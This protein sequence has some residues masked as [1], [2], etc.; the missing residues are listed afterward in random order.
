VKKPKTAPKLLSQ[1]KAF[2][3][4]ARALCCDESEERFDAALAKVARHKPTG[5]VVVAEKE[6]KTA[7]ELKELVEKAILTTD[8]SGIQWIKIVPDDPSRG[9]NWRVA[10]SGSNDGGLWEKI[11]RA[12]EKLKEIYD[13]R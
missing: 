10:H 5:D 11:E 3:Q 2:V 4:A 13:M 12:Y 1:S 7:E 9:A 8:A 6:M